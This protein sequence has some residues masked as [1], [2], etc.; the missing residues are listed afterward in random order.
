MVKL[1]RGHALGNVP[2]FIEAKVRRFLKSVEVGSL[3]TL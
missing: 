1:L 3:S 2:L